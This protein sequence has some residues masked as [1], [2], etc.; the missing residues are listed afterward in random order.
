MHLYM[1]KPRYLLFIL[2]N[3]ISICAICQTANLKFEHIGT[4]AGLS[5]SNV[6]CILEDSRGFMWFGTRDGLDKYDGYQFTVYKSIEGDQK[7]ISNNF[8]TGLI[9]DKKGDLWVATWG[10]GLNRF[11]REKNRF[12]HHAGGILSEIINNVLQDTRGNIWAGTNGGGLFKLDPDKDKYIQYLHDESNPRSLSNNDVTA[13]FEDSR[14]RIWVGTSHSGLNLLDSERGT[15]THFRH[16][17]KDSSSSSSD[18][19]MK[20]FEDSRHRLWIG[21]RG[22]GLELFNSQE[23]KFRN[24]R[25][26]PNNRNSLAHDAILSLCGDDNCSLWIGTENGGISILGPDLDKFRNLRHDEIDNTSLSTNSIYS[27]YKDRRGN[28]WVGTYSGGINLYNRGENKFLHYKHNSYPG[29]LGNNNVLDIMED[30][31]NNLWIGTDGGGLDLFNREKGDFRHFRRKTPGKKGICGD[32]VLAL[33][34]DGQRNLWVGTWGDGLT[35]INKERNQF[36]QYKHDPGNPSS[37]S[38]NNVY[39]IA[40]DKEKTIWAGTFGDGLDQ[41]D[42]KKD[43]FVHY[44]HDESNPNSLS[45]DRVHSMLADSKGFLWVGTFDGGLDLFDKK[46]NV[47]THYRH[48]PAK[49]SLSNNSVN[50]IF[51][52]SHGGIWIGTTVGLNFLNRQTGRFTSY[53]AKDGLAGPMIFGILED[54]KGNLWLS[55]NNGLSRFNPQTRTF[56]NFTAADGLQS[57]EFKAHACFKSPSGNMYFGGVNGFNVFSPDSVKESPFE[58]SL[59]ITGFQLFS[60][61]VPVSADGKNDSPLKRDI[62]ETKAITLSYKQ[63]VISFE[64]ASLNYTSTAKKQYAYKLDGFDKDWNYIGTKRTATYTN[65]DPGH[66]VFMVKGLNS[67]GSWS[68]NI[69]SIQLTITP[70]FWETWWF[71]LLVVLAVTGSVI[72]IHRIRVYSIKSQKK[73][74]ERQVKE[75][76]SQ[77]ALSIEEER[78][79]RQE[80]ESANQAKSEFMANMSHELRTP[81]NAIIGFTDLMLTN[82]LPKAQREYLDNV[83]RSGYSLLST[84]NDILDYSKIEAGKLCIDNSIFSLGNLVEETI[85]MLAIKAFEKNLEVIGEIDPRFPDQVLGDPMRVRQILVNLIGNAIKFTEEGEIAVSV[86]KGDTIY[87]EHGRKCQRMIIAVRDTGIGIHEEKIREIFE[88]FTQADSSTTR[89]YG[90]TGLGLTI[91]K[92]LAEMMGGSLEV[93]SQPGKGSVF[94]LHLTLEIIHE[95]PLKA[96]LSR[97]A[98]RRILVVDDN[99]TNCRLMKDIFDYMGI[100]CILCTSGMDA[101]QTLT[102]ALSENEL[103]DLIIT[104]NQ[105]PV[106]DGI[107]LVKEIKRLLKHRPQPFILML[108]SLEK[109]MF[110]TEAESIGIDL[111][112]SK[113]VKLHELSHILASIFDKNEPAEKTAPAGR[114]VN[115]LTKGTSILV[116]EDEPVNM[117]LISEVLGKMGFRVI[118][119][120]TGN[121]VIKLLEVHDPMIIFMDVNMP[122]MDGF[123]ATR[124]IRAL[125]NPQSNIPIVALTADAMKE[126]MERCLEAGMNHFISKPFRL[127][128]IEQLLKQYMSLA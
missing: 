17:D 88:S 9:E 2:L 101:L 1:K 69:A 80:A 7:S 8:I 27:L 121:E 40:E 96:A 4:E 128:E 127:E 115:Q 79:A 102:K 12:I 50:Y 108:S 92:N 31:G 94:S 61:D 89:K 117:L 106:M 66:Y 105:M 32:Y 86:K 83:H 15:F 30:S 56:K 65:L 122:E 28:M 52:D 55:T 111:F 43:R 44:K 36:R 76:T 42:A 63:S 33:C 103:F 35:V 47:F 109:N 70:P 97:P 81:M 18:A 64:F 119:A 104:D 57:N 77:L 48:D 24:F 91:A 21:T 10:G 75:R 78:N 5:Q 6:T 62:T 22:G 125:G 72:I 110:R 90:G 37:I 68:H 54:D 59:M 41:Y 93:E 39:A 53:S 85:D 118:K 112:L 29:S 25:N 58:P 20:V 51:E 3:T 46:T 38:G 73:A 84:I 19:V 74:L 107:T 113:P 23:G 98:L 99:I 45:S 87:D 116:A 100:D 124:A 67:A 34:E 11:D 60:R 14:R 49:N 120:T 16:C 126:D 13:I 82:D 26:D 123:C 95:Q 71:R 114:I